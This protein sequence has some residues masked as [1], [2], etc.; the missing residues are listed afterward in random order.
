EP[1]PSGVFSQRCHSLVSFRRLGEPQAGHTPCIHLQSQLRARRAQ[2]LPKLA[3]PKTWSSLALCPIGEVSLHVRN[4]P[5]KTSAG[6]G[7]LA[8]PSSKPC[9]CAQGCAF[10]VTR[11]AHDDQQ[12]KAAHAL[13]HQREKDRQADAYCVLCGAEYD[14]ETEGLCV[15]DLP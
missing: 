10:G 3:R 7:S 1:D 14:R 8:K 13:D 4:L 5:A 6:F 2:Q 11:T 12:P 15:A 9:R